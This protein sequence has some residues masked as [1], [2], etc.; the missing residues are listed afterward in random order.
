MDD[1][2]KN[3]PEDPD[4]KTMLRIEMKVDMYHTMYEMWNWDGIWA[5]S[6]IFLT[7][8][9]K[10]LSEE[11]LKKVVVNSGMWNSESQILVKET[12]SGYT[13]VNFNYTTD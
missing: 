11:D 10:K 7:E 13:F 6:L 3:I 1:K 2:F 4:T 5:E 12:E 8:D 9:I